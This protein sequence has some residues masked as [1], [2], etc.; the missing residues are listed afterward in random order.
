MT[1]LKGNY[2]DGSQ[3]IN[4]P[5]QMEFT[6]REVM[7]SAGS[8]CEQYSI[9]DLMVSPR[10]GSTDRFINVPN[11]GQFACADSTF[12]DILPQE[13][14]SE[15]FVAWLE[16]RWGIALACIALILGALLA[17]YFLGLPIAAEHIANR[18]PME[19]EQSLGNQ[20]VKWLENQ[21]WLEPTALDTDIR[22]TIADGFISICSDLPMKN[23]YQLEFRSSRILRANALAL[24]GGTIIVTD[25]MVKMGETPEEVLAILAH[26]I[27]H[28][29]SRHAVRNILQQSIIAAAVTIITADA[30]SLSTVVTSLP[31][32]LAQTRYA[33]EFETAA[34]DFA[35]KL[36]KR[37]GY[38]PEAF[39]SIMERIA[40]KE[41]YKPAGF[42][43]VSTH[44]LTTERINRARAAAAE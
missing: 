23:Y 39:A 33:R 7:L 40:K 41:G 31:M 26:E 10:I 5:A 12:L 11:G 38:S 20:A 34:D 42:A 4:I 25:D 30:A 24:P 8:I 13:S 43:Y 3:P 44:P 21:K 2:F 32:L 29:E 19:T 16:K 22:N 17:G 15:G 14:P 37:K 27:G 36:L 1:F 35:F 9:S 18:I 6:D 28:V